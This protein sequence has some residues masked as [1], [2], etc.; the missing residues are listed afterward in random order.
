MAQKHFAIDVRRD[1]WLRRPSRLRWFV[2]SLLAIVGVIFVI[3]LP[4]AI[5][6]AEDGS[7]SSALAGAAAILALATPYLYFAGRISRA[8]IWDR[9]KRHRDPRTP[10]HPKDPRELGGSRSRP[11]FSLAGETEPHARS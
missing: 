11:A 10:S 8:G 1:A 3:A 6:A 4:R 5:G 2:F 9:G 7:I